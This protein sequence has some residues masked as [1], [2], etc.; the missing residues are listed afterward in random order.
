MFARDEVYASIGVTGHLEE[1]K[2]I[3]AAILLLQ[4]FPALGARLRLTGVPFLDLRNPQFL[5][6][7]ASWPE[8]SDEQPYG[9]LPTPYTCRST[10]ACR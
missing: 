3:T 7:C 10:I 8:G 2:L 4:A 5:L 1:D 6:S 9:Q